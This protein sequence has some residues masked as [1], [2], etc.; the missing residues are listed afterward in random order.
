MKDATR[1]RL[2]ALVRRVNR[3]RWYRKW[4][5]LKDYGALPGLGTRAA[6]RYVLTDP[7]VGDFSYVVTNVEDMARFVGRLTGVDEQAAREALREAEQDHQL[8]ADLDAHG[9]PDVL[10]ASPAVGARTIWYAVIRLTR[11]G[12]VVETGTWYGVGAC[13]M[14]RALERNAE[15]GHP[16]RLLSFDPD[17]TAGWLVPGRHAGHWRLVAERTE[18]AL[19]REL[20]GQQVGMFVHDTP[21]IYERERFE[22]ERAAACAAA[23]GAVLISGNGRNTDALG[24][25]AASWDV[26]LRECDLET[27][28]WY[29]PQGTTGVRIDGPVP[30]G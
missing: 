1:F 5:N 17:P 13:V 2:K 26:V 30:L 20:E 8:R 22:F 6:L 29:T 14:L 19:A 12:L 10:A 21:S 11:P 24:D 27:D 9:R 4:R 18:D 25:L 7:E 28:S 3:L 16:G 15:E 23:T